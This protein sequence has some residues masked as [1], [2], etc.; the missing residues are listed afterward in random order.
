[1][2]IPASSNINLALLRVVDPKVLCPSCTT[3]STTVSTLFRQKIEKWAGGLPEDN[4]GNGTWG[5]WDESD[6]EAMDELLE[7]RTSVDESRDEG[8][9]WWDILDLD[10]L[11]ERDGDAD[12]EVIDGCEMLVEV[13]EPLEFV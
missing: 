3:N 13:A 8:Q 1:M 7:R 5:L 12:E 9:H 6:S 10:E 11:L 2:G 4:S